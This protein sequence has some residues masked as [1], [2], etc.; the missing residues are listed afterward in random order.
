MPEQPASQSL[1]LQRPDPWGGLGRFISR[2]ALVPLYWGIPVLLWAALAGGS[3]WWNWQ[4]VEAHSF[5]VASKQ[6]RQIAS[7][8]EAMRLWNAGHGG[9]YVWT[10]DRLQPNPYLDHPDRDISLPDG[11]TL[12]M[13]NPA[14]MTRGLTD[15]VRDSAGVRV[16]L[17]SLDPINPGNQAD[18]WEAGVLQDFE[19]AVEAEAPGGRV[20]AL[21]HVELTRSSLPEL[22]YMRALRVKPECMQ[23]HRHQGYE[24]GDIRGGLSVTLPAEPMFVLARQQKAALAGFHGLV[25]LLLS[26]GTV[27]VLAR[28]RQQILSLQEANSQQDRL[29]HLRTRELRTEVAERQEAEARLRLLIDSSAEGILAVNGE[30]VC[31][32]CNPVAADL[33]GYRP[34]QLVGQPLRDLIAH[35]DAGGKPRDVRHCPI[36]AA[37]RAGQVAE[38]LDSVFWRVDGTALPVEYRAHPIRTTGGVVGAVISFRDIRE[39][40]RNE[41]QLRALHAGVENSPAAIAIVRIDGRIDYVNPEFCRL[42][43]Y[44]AD[45]LLGQPIQ[46]LHCEDTA[47]AVYRELWQTVRAGRTWRGEL[48]SRRR[49][50]TAFWERVSISAIRDG[51]GQPTQA[52]AVCEDV[53]EQKNAQDEV[54]RRAHYDALTGLPNRTLF[55]ERLAQQLLQAARREELLAVLFV[56]LDGFKQVNDTLG[57]EAGDAVLREAGQRMLECLRASDTVARLGGDEFA[58]IVLGANSVRELAVVTQRLLDVLARPFDC[59]DR[60]GRIAGSIGIALHQPGQ[61][62]TLEALLR[63]ADMAMYRA[64]RKGGSTFCFAQAERV[65]VDPDIP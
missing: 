24:V 38:E 45:E 50:G 46:R 9:V 40:K 17:T 53:T 6:A 52:V 16:H 13:V 3:L 23:C 37:Y 20:T 1:P 57:H 44:R 48:A 55:H 60:E 15:I 28:L 41:A 10:S 18:L 35:S 63:Q 33:L 21:E 61:A 14:F 51:S 39:R 25:W 47:P 29:V 31:T 8:M 58:L 42:N 22:R 32:L 2:L 54:W 27:M 64:K 26:A 59:G 5:E 49:D 36:N 4:A 19:R 34:E 11:R 12:T 65:A 7:M 30:G 43:G 56:D 62:T